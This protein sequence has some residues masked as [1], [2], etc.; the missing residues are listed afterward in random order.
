MGYIEINNYKIYYNINGNGYP[1]ILLHD[2][3][4]STETWDTVREQL[5]KKFMVIDYDRYG[6]GKSSHIETFEDEIIEF[7]TK[8]LKEFVNKLELKEFYLCGHCLGG[9]IAINY[10]IKNQ[11]R[12]KKLILESVGL[13]SDNLIQVKCDWVFKPFEDLDNGFRDTLIKMHGDSLYSKTFWNII[14]DDKKS[15]IMNRNY[16]F[17]DKVKKL[18]MPVFFIYGDSDFY[19]DIE[20][21]ITGFKLLKRSNL[22]ISPNTNHIVH[23]EKSENFIENVINFL[24][25][26]CK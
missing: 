1:L 11:N 10:A 17:R 13:Y 9:A 2:G 19:F 4:Y 26:N 5:S 8:E 3:F 24:N 22:W 18:K 23:I 12:V 7:S 21:A 15:Y 14:R 25:N 16:D 6:Y 20:H